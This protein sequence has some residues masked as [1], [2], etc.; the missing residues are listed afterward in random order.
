[1]GDGIDRPD[2]SGGSGGG[3]H[4]ETLRFAGNAKPVQR[5]D[6]GNAAPTEHVV[7]LHIVPPG[8]KPVERGNW[9]DGDYR[10]MDEV[11]TS[12]TVH[13]LDQE[14]NKEPVEH[15]QESGQESSQGDIDPVV[16]DHLVGFVGRA[17]PAHAAMDWLKSVEGKELTKSEPARHAYDL[18]GLEVSPENLPYL[19]AFANHMARAG[20][21][22][23]EFSKSIEWAQT[24][25]RN[26]AKYEQT[27]S[28]QQVTAM[29]Q[30]EAVDVEH[31]DTAGMRLRAEWQTDYDTNIATINRYLETLPKDER[32][33]LVRSRIDGRAFGNDPERLKEF[34]AEA[35]TSQKDEGLSRQEIEKILRTNRSRYDRDPA[36]QSRYRQLLQTN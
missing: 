24:L 29:R 10:N 8:T 6:W 2:W 36:M 20:A 22:Q 9:G 23:S 28:S 35:K 30:I 31:R 12:N 34:L 5:G 13:P 19:Q 11:R 27:Q 1:M 16:V 32:E 17:E 14:A 26:V 3:E 25:T 7:G 4:V 18:R 15:D 21:S 33:Y